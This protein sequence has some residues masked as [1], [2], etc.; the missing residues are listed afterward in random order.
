MSRKSASMLSFTIGKDPMSL[1]NQFFLLRTKASTFSDTL[2]DH[3]G[4]QPHLRRR[5]RK[6]RDKIRMEIP[7]ILGILR[8]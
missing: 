3:D 1:L 6:P 8:W 2:F 4:I 5:P 7:T